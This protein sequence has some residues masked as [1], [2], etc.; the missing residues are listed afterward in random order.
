MPA[1]QSAS[2]LMIGLMLLWPSSRSVVSSMIKS[3]A[4]RARKGGAVSIRSVLIR[5]SDTGPSTALCA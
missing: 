5:R 3:S 1:I 2:R 4:S